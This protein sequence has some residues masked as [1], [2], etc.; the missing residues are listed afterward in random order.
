MARENEKNAV[1][2]QITA[3]ANEHIAATQR[4]IAEDQKILAEENAQ[5]ANAQRSAAEAKIHQDRV[6]ELHTSTLLALDAYQRLPGLPDAENILR[7]NISL[8]PMPIKQM[9][10]SARIWTIM[11]TPDGKILLRLTPT[12]KPV[13]GAWRMARSYSALQHDGIV[14]DFAMSQDGK[15]PGYRDRKGTAHFLGYEYTTNR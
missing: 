2:S 5:K 6:G 12:A 1:N 11:A 8:L 4:A 3:E 13:F 14:Y 10:V 7:H 9:N 15:Y